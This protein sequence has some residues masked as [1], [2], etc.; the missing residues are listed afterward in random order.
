MAAVSGVLR[1]PRTVIHCAWYAMLGVGSIPNAFN[2]IGILVS[3]VHVFSFLGLL[4]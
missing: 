4:L 2:N 3:F 1:N